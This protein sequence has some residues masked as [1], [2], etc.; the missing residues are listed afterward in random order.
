VDDV[1]VDVDVDLMLIEVVVEVWLKRLSKKKI[2]ASC[3]SMP[4]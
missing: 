4:K 3:A 2:D 1:D